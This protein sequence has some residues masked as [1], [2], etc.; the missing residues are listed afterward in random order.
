MDAA[1]GFLFVLIVLLLLFFGL[2]LLYKN[3]AVVGKW[4][5]SP[6]YACDDRELKLHRRIEDAQTELDSI[7]E[8]KTETG[9]G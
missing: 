6:Y 2:A 1:I 8:K 3:R 4:L 7:S 5:N 9:G